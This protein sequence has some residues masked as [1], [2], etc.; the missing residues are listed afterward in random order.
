MAERGSQIY[1]GTPNGVVLTIDERNDTELK[2]K[3]YTSYSREAHEVTNW[4]QFFFEVEKFFDDL[5]FPYPTTNVR[6][7]GEEIKRSYP[8]PGK[9]KVM[10]DEELL[11]KHGDLGSFII[12]V[13]H[14][15]NSS[16]QG[17]ITWMEKN[18]TMYF[19]S[20]WEMMKLIESALDTVAPPEET[21]E[22]SWE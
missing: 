20:A 14:R 21:E 9:E 6:T 1:I 5:R 17:R 19:R 11:S 4:D 2:A 3:Y 10:K 13:Q 18:Q 12:R 7:F 15:Q 22:P 16:W 8:E